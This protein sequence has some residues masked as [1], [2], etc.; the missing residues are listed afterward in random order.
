[1]SRCKASRLCIKS[2]V[3]CFPALPFFT[4]PG[5]S[6]TYKQHISG[7]HE[8]GRC[9]IPCICNAEERRRVHNKVQQRV[10]YH[11][12]EDFPL[13]NPTD[14]LLWCHCSQTL[15]PRLQTLDQ[16]LCYS[17]HLNQSLRSHRSPEQ[18]EFLPQTHVIKE[19]TMQW[20]CGFCDGF[21]DFFLFHS[22]VLRPF[23]CQTL[24][25]FLLLPLLTPIR[26]ASVRY[27]HL[28]RCLCCL[29]FFVPADCNSCVINFKSS[30]SFPLFF[31][32]FFLLL[33]SLAA[34][35]RLSSLS[36]TT[37]VAVLVAGFFTPVLLALLLFF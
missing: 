7:H 36:L 11:P 23:V 14:P 35:S 27:T 29:V 10:I 2:S 21:L 5:S 26:N 30:S 17:R 12:E 25:S 31:L 28:G 33:R 24:L 8:L 18:K 15:S 37:S 16:I 13:R 20:T 4:L 3:A 1:M 22:R 19:A 34:A 32:F 6:F 9:Y